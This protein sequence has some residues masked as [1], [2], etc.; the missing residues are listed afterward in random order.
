MVLILPDTVLG[1]LSSLP[2]HEES[3]LLNYLG[4]VTN[5]AKQDLVVLN[6]Q[7]VASVLHSVSFLVILQV[8][9]RLFSLPSKSQIQDVLEYC[10]CSRINNPFVKGCTLQH[11]SHDIFQ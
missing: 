3:R 1:W 4:R 2:S 8:N 11:K 6:W 9:K 5:H 10:Y 7:V